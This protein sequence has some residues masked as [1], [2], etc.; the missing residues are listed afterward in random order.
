MRPG[1]GGWWISQGSCG[2]AKHGDPGWNAKAPAGFRSA[3]YMRHYSRI[4][5][6]RHDQLVIPT[7]EGSLGEWGRWRSN[8]LNSG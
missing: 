2:D 7:K 3:A 6:M 8:D 5:A 4:R 1:G